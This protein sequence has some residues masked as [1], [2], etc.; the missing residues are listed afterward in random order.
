[1]SRLGS[2]DVINIHHVADFDSRA[3]RGH[4]GQVATRNAYSFST[5]RPAARGS[6]LTQDTDGSWAVESLPSCST[7]RNFKTYEP[8]SFECKC[9][10]QKHVKSSEI[11]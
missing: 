3:T 11:N 6:V 9:Q 1:M 2:R 8:Y 5:G 10:R 4:L 7:P